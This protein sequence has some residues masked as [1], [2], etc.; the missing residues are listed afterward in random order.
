ML[1]PLSLFKHPVFLSF[2]FIA[3]FAHAQTYS[4]AATD[5]AGGAGRA[6]VE[7]GD[8]NY[9]NPAALVHLKGRFIYSTFSK[10]DLSIGLS[11]SSKDVLMPASLSYF[12]RR[13]EDVGYDSISTQQFRLSIADFVFDRF[14]MGLTGIMDTSKMR[15]RTYNQT[16]GNLGFFY[17]PS[18]HLGAAFVFYNVFGV[19]E[20]SPEVVRLQPQMGLGLHGIYKNFLRLRG[21]VLSGTNNDFGRPKYMG[22]FETVLNEWLIARIGYQND[23]KGSQELL[24]AGIGFNG[25]VFAFNY[26]HQGNMKGP[27]FDRH[28][29]DLLISF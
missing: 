27:E 29:I 20:N 15:D 3:S 10:D 17:T 19:N 5:S 26:A 12:S 14:S 28:S 7:A 4:S 24:T 21:D 25:P 13:M 9:L 11:E 8:I 16:N 18:D 1:N 6:A 23:I 2:Y 22:G